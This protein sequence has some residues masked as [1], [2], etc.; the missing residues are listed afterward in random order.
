MLIFGSPKT[1]KGKRNHK[2][3][4]HEGNAAAPTTP[5]YLR[6]F[7][8]L[9][10]FDRHDHP[11]HIINVGCFPL[12]VELMIEDIRMTKVHIDGDNDINILYKDTFDKLNVEC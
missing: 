11:D 7:E 10:T 5:I 4:L 9:I 1:Y 8:W 6:W 12:M 3:R 2:L